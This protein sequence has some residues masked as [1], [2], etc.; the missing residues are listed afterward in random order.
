MCIRDS[1]DTDINC[2][3]CNLCNDSG[4][5]DLASTIVNPTA[6]GAGT[7][8]VTGPGNTNI[9]LNGTILD[10]TGLPAGLYLSLIHI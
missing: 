1:P 10:A 5:L 3:N 4:I 8:K 2:I 6:I 7:W 9:P